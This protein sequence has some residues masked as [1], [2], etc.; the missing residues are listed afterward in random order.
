MFQRIATLLMGTVRPI[1][2]YTRVDVTNF[3]IY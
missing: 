2:T 1:T 3:I